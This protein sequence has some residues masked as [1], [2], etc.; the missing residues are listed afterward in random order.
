MEIG[1]IG[2]WLEN[3]KNTNNKTNIQREDVL[4]FKSNINK[5][6]IGRRIKED[7]LGGR[8]IVPAKE[9]KLALVQWIEQQLRKHRIR[10]L[11]KNPIVNLNQ[12]DSF[13]KERIK[14]G[15]SK[16]NGVSE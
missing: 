1:K 16:T 15:T 4:H 9:K 8:V 5:R 2:T 7:K 14:E 3:S 13:N 6:I 11:I 10:E 12:N